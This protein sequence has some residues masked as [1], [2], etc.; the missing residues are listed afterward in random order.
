MLGTSS[1]A[2]IAGGPNPNSTRV[3]LDW[4]YSKEGISIAGKAQGNK[5]ARSDVHDFR[6]MAVQTT[7][8]KPLVITT[9][10]LAKATRFYQEKWF[11]KL[12]GR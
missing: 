3:L 2:A 4:I 8:S 6:A 12:V 7:M 1:V 10:H 5:M 9:E 11:D